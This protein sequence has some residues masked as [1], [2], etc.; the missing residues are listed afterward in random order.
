MIKRPAYVNT[1]VSQFLSGDWP[2][3]HARSRVR[4]PRRR[5]G[6]RA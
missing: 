1:A 4:L 6:S 2:G 3:Q 5:T